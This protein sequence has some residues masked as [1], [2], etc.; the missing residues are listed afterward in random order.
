MGP[1]MMERAQRSFKSKL[2]ITISK[3]KN[4]FFL[5][6]MDGCCEWGPNN[7]IIIWLQNGSK[8]SKL[9]RLPPPNIIG[10]PSHY[11]FVS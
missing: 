8:A 2:Q 6:G 11:D 1:P 9:W 7:S 5:L 3:G 10:I 4:N